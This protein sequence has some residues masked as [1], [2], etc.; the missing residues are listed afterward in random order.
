MDVAPQN[1]F[2]RNISVNY[3]LVIWILR[4]WVGYP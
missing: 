1:P 2:V 4:L 3:N